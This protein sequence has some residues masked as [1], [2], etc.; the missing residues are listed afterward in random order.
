MPDVNPYDLLPT[1]MRITLALYD[2]LTQ[3]YRHIA[4]H[5]RNCTVEN[6]EQWQT[7]LN[8]LDLAIAQVNANR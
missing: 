5:G 7:I 1:R 3:S 2:P 8:A 6:P 4:K